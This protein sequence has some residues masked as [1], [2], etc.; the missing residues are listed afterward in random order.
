M[1]EEKEKPR[2]NG[3]TRS[4]VPLSEKKDEKEKPKKEK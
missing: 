4:K 1:T 3:S 2:D